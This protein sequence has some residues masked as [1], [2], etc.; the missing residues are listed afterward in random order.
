MLTKLV[1]WASTHCGPPPP[2]LLLSTQRMKYTTTFE[3]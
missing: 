1:M 2:P 3:P